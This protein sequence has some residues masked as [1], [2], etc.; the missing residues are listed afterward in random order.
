MGEDRIMKTEII[1]I[2]NYLA[3]SKKLIGKSNA[4]KGKLPRFCTTVKPPET[5]EGKEA[6]FDDVNKEWIIQDIASA[7]SSGLVTVYGYA[8][9]TMV[10]IGSAE[11]MASNLP[12]NSTT[13]DPGE[14]PPV[15]YCQVF[16]LT[17]QKWQT[18]EDH[19]RSTVWS[20]TDATTVYI[21][22]PGPL[23]D[24]V[25][26]LSPEGIPHPMWDGSQWVTDTSRER[27]ATVQENKAAY[28]SL[29]QRVMLA[30]CPLASMEALGVAQMT[31]EQRQRLADLRT[32]AVELSRLVAS[33][34]LT[35]RLVFP[36]ATPELLEPI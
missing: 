8:S 17:S 20:T 36:I 16:D 12:P 34:D 7:P 15:G 11:A 21:H 29:M 22:K 10:Y 33:A 27:L 3:D 2:W 24:N 35:Q 26:T 1:D 18:V 30:Q 31:D 19:R 14:R 9:D 6:V 28:S 32:Y 4:V 25:T 5:A 23:P 13:T